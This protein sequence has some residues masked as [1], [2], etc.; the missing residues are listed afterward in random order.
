MALNTDLDSRVLR[1]STGFGGLTRP[2]FAHYERGVA[3]GAQCPH[4][5]SPGPIEETHCPSCG[6]STGAVTAG[7][8]PSLRGSP[9]L[10]VTCDACDAKYGTKGSVP[11]SALSYLAR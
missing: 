7:L 5:P 4:C 3:S 2:R 10:T 1:V 9:A 8:P 6:A 11:A